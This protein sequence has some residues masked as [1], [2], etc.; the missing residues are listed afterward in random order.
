MRWPCF[1]IPSAFAAIS[2]SLTEIR[3]G[4]VTAPVSFSGSAGFRTWRHVFS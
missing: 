1:E 2:M 4:A 3:G